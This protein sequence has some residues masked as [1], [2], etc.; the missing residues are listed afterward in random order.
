MLATMLNSMASEHFE[1]SLELQASWGIRWLDLKD[2]IYGADV[3]NLTDE[4]ARDAAERIERSGMNVYCLTT[5]IFKDGLE[6]GERSYRERHLASFDRLVELSRLLRPQVVRVLGPRLNERERIVNA[7]DYLQSMTPWVFPLYRECID[8]LGEMGIRTAFENEPEHTVFGEPGE[9]VDFFAA[10]DRPAQAFFTYDVQ[11]MWQM[12][13]FPSLEA[14]SRLQPVIGYLHVKGGM[15]EPGSDDLRWMSALEDA[16]WPVRELVERAEA[17]GVAAVCLNPSH[18]ERK[19]GYD[20]SAI[21]E[22][23]LRFIQNILGH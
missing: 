14:Y 1:R 4:Q 11:N 5:G 10:L 8:R 6:A 22:R 20:D 12:G 19:P 18:G 13:V 17:D 21:V 15:R 9:T 2:R 7:A 23:D 16:S 3:M